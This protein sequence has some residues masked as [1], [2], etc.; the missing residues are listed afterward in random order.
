MISFAATKS[1]IDKK[2]FTIYDNK[3]LKNITF[4]GSCRLSPLIEIFQNTK[5]IREEYNICYIICYIYKFE[6]KE[7]PYNEINEILSRTDVLIHEFITSFDDLNT[8]KSKEFNVYKKFNFNPKIDICVPNFD[9][10]FTLEHIL[11]DN[12]KERNYVKYLIEND[13]VNEENIFILYEK[14]FISSFKR[15]LTNID[16]TSIPELSNY[17]KSN[18]K[19]I[20]LFNSTNHTSNVLCLEIGLNILNNFFQIK[21][22]ESFLENY[23]N[24][25][26]FLGGNELFSKY[27]KMY[28]NFIFTT[29][30]ETEELFEKLKIKEI[31]L[32]EEDIEYFEMIVE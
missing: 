19:K 10:T 25:Q 28:H 8:D 21:P 17:M 3:C 20:R 29:N 1:Q 11:K 26:E 5:K 14:Y 7:L 15:L 16:R 23:Y 9:L 22:D 12:E 2:Q 18:F 30:D 13:K 32:D 6:E 24:H 4:L 31:I 27:D